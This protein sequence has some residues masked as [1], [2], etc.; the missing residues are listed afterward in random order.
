MALSTISSQHGSLLQGQQK[1]LSPR[2]SLI[3]YNSCGGNT[4]SPLLLEKQITCPT[5]SLGKGILENITPAGRDHE[6]ILEFCL[7][8]WGCPSP[9]A[10][11]RI[12]TSANLTGNKSCLVFTGIL[13]LPVKLNTFLY[14]YWIF[15]YFIFCDV[16]AL[17]PNFYWNVSTNQ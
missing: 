3:K 5:L 11:P 2:E 7:S 9:H 6:A 15:S 8:Q 1:T 10:N 16:S 14:I 12:S 4:P 13:W 17:C